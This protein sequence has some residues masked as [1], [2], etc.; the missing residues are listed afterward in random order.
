[1]LRNLVKTGAASALHWSGVTRWMG[2]DAPLILSYHRVVEDFS[3]HV[4]DSIPPM[5]ITTQMLERQL[6]WVGGRYTFVSLDELAAAMENGRKPTRRVAAVTFDDGYADVYHHALPLLKRKGIPAAVFVVSDLIGTR[7][8]QYHDQLYL[9]LLRAFASKSPRDVISHLRKSGIRPPEA[10]HLGTDVID[11]SKTVNSLLAMLPRAEIE[12]LIALLES[13][14]DFVPLPLETHRSVTWEMIDEMHRAGVV[15]GSH[16]RTHAVLP[17]ESPEKVLEEI[18][19]SRIELERRL[20]TSV[21][22]FAY[23]DGRFN[24]STI[25]AVAAS[26][27]RYA[28]TTSRSRQS[29]YRLFTI[30]RRVLWE[31][32]C[33]DPVGRFS[34]ALLDCLIHG[35]FDRGT[36]YARE[37]ASRSFSSPYELNTL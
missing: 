19:G 6:D 28:Y 12:R 10:D 37:L 15:I 7:T 22:H 16:T 5:L 3:Q 32:S 26:G 21:R 4:H 35:I 27:Y 9:L 1:M 34:P 29:G 36:P 13:E 31:N 17:N 33:T 25:N 30:P 8:L 18:E 2:N 11:Y 23:P 14:T 20:Q 24:Q